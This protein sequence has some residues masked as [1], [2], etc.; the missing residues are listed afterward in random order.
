MLRVSEPNAISNAIFGF[1]FFKCDQI[2]IKNIISHSVCVRLFPM[3]P[4]K[5]F[6]IYFDK[7]LNQIDS[8][9]EKWTLNLEGLNKLQKG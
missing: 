7:N 3:P 8:A 1:Y 6:L 2:T 4:V 5:R 9:I